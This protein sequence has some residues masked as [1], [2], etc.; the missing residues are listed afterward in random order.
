M[1]GLERRKEG[2]RRV[3]LREGGR[4]V[5]GP[6]R[7][8]EVGALERRKEGG[9]CTVLREGKKEGGGWS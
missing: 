2:E 3:I 9:R 7:R 8:R 5:G 1:G 6:E 4:E